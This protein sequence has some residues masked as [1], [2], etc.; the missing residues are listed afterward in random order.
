MQTIGCCGY[1][2]GSVLY[3]AGSLLSFLK[4][5]GLQSVARAQMS[6]ALR[7]QAAWSDR[8]RSATTDTSEADLEI[9]LCEAD[10][11]PDP[12]PTLN[13]V[14]AR[15]LRERWEAVV[16]TLTPRAAR[17]AGEATPQSILLAAIDTPHSQ[18][19]RF[20]GSGSAGN[21]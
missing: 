15:D 4:T 21:H 7:I 17:R 9:E 8:Q 5:L 6:A 19:G 3:T 10:W 18:Q 2:A 1:F 12:G 20:S 11:F 16:E 14:L 13:S